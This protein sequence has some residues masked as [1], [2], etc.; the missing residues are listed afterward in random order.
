V[1]VPGGAGRPKPLRKTGP[2]AAALVKRL[3]RRD[4]SLRKIAVKLAEAGYLNE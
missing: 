2:K 1:L 3:S 4:L